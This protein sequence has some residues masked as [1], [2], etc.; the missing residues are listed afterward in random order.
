LIIPLFFRS[1]G[2]VIG[3]PWYPVP[4]AVTLGALY[5][6]D[7]LKLR[8]GVLAICKWLGDVSYP[9]YLVHLPVFAILAVRGNTD[10]IA[11][12]AFVVI[13]AAAIDLV[14]DKPIK[15]FVSKMR[16]LISSA[17]VAKLR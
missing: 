15:H 7:R 13:V 17:P 9:L 12:I 16:N 11:A 8:A 6:G 3:Y 2:R 4:W 1:D 14:Y 5:Y 10:G